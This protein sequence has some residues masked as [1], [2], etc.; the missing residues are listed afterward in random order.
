MSS[1]NIHKN[2][3]THGMNKLGA[4]TRFQ[5]F[6]NLMIE[7]K[8]KQS[9]Y[10]RKRTFGVK[11]GNRHKNNESQADRNA[12]AGDAKVGGL[13]QSFLG[14]TLAMT[15]KQLSIFCVLVTNIIF[16]NKDILRE[17]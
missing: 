6:F 1:L 8:K 3:Y 7:I 10:N 13:L 9:H 17:P 16:N 5:D 4:K 15:V 14:L 12:V 2:E 11:R